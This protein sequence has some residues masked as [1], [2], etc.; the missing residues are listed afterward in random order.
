M[1]MLALY[2]KGATFAAPTLDASTTKQNEM[3]WSKDYYFYIKKKTKCDEG[4]SICHNTGPM[5]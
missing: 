4:E 3:K 2:S 5:R 1:R